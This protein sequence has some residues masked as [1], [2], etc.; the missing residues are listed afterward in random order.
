[1]NL[2]LI[3]AVFTAI[4]SL[5]VALIAE[6][7]HPVKTL[8]WILVLLFL[9]GLGLIFYFLFGTNK[10]N[11]RLLSDEEV[12]GF[13]KR[14]LENYYDNIVN[15]ENET[16]R[17]LQMTNK[18]IP[19]G[20]NEVTV[21]TDFNSM[22]AALAEDMRN[23]KNHIN[24]QFFKIE[25]DPIGRALAEIM[26]ERA[27]KGVDVKVL[28]DDAANLSRKKFYKWM[29]N[30]GIHVQ[31]FLRV[32]IPFISSNTNYRNHRKVV[33]IDGNI[34][35][36][37]GMNIAERYSVGIRSG[38]WRDTHFRVRGPAASELQTSFLVDWLFTSKRSIKDI[39]MYYPAYKP[40]GN[41]QM[42]IATSGVMDE[43]HVTMQGMISLI[44][45]AK[46]YV[47]LES[48]YFIPTDTFMMALRNAALS[49]VDVRIIIP[50]RGDRG[51]LTPLATRSYVEAAL[52]AGV[53]VY[54]YNGGYMH[55]KTIVTDDTA[56]TIGSTNIDIR[57]FEQDF[58]ANGFF[59]DENV[60]VTLRKAFL[61]DQENSTQVHLEE[62]LQ[63]PRTE[64]LLESFA[65]LFSMLL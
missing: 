44:T 35:Y 64:K 55:S 37:G 60:A 59:Y 39:E 2:W 5:V 7:R 10:K 27:S 34:G 51:F 11:E 17:L 6:N 47:Y 46:K 52:R 54:F 4:L 57:S 8:A 63:R 29:K 24:F 53:K 9:P 49:G 3:V 41:V 31:P 36:C 13:K 45:L 20:G 50:Y 26:A 25:D 40:E 65:R 43:W 12:D 58:E 14:T 56:A 48:P 18:A 33:V 32:V 15:I 42:Q 1:M 23:A 22:F 21:Y 30:R 38:N 62:W 19:L 16:S 61:K 28:Y